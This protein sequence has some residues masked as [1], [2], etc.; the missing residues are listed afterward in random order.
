MEIEKEIVQSK[1]RSPLQKGIVNIIFTSNWIHSRQAKVLK[2]FGLTIQQYNI[3]RIL[4]GQHPNPAS[5][6]LLTERMLDKMS[7]AS[8]LVEKLLTKGLVERTVCPSDRRQVNVVINDAG[9]ELLEQMGKALDTFEN[10]TGNLNDEELE[11]LSNLLD[12]LRG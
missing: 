7:N 12:R 5:I 10:G 6:T 9:L 11:T 1:F 8:R 4:R 3:L 2:P